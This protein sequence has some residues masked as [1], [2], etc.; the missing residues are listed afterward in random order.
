MA[1]SPDACT[2]ACDAVAAGAREGSCSRVW[3]GGGVPVVR[4]VAVSPCNCALS[5]CLAC[6]LGGL[7]PFK[8]ATLVPALLRFK[9]ACVVCG[10]LYLKASLEWFWCRAS[11]LFGI[12]LRV[13]VLFFSLSIPFLFELCGSLVCQADA[14]APSSTARPPQSA[15]ACVLPPRFGR[16]RVS[17]FIVFC[18]LFPSPRPLIRF[19]LCMS[20]FVGWFL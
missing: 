8:D 6:F 4:F 17:D 5:L 19:W 14:G 16:A 18:C 13:C 1:C 15:T 20:S 9:F 3:T 7:H 12:R 10:P 2:G 11:V